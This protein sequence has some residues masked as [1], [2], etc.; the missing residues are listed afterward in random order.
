MIPVQQIIQM[1][2][3]VNLN[4]STLVEIQWQN[5]SFQIV[6][7]NGFFALTVNDHAVNIALSRYCGTK[8]PPASYVLSG[9]ENLLSALKQCQQIINEKEARTEKTTTV[10]NDPAIGKSKSKQRSAELQKELDELRRQ[11]AAVEKTE[12]ET[13]I[14]QRNGQ[15]KLREF[16]MINEGG[17]CIVTGITVPE[18]LR[19]SHITAW[20]EDPIN[21]LVPENVL[22][23]AAHLDALFDKHLIS[24][25]PADGHMLINNGISQEDRT[26]LGLSEELRIPVSE[27]RRVFLQQHFETFCKKCKAAE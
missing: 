23:L 22:L 13:T 12:R 14:K 20:K 26:A 4:T 10:E 1:N 19:A 16:L 15:Q 21:R 5:H 9:H 7:R 11:L 25:D 18:V 17:C 3:L 2:W 24:F 8:I 6:E 27:G